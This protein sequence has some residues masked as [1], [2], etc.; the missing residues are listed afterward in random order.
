MKRTA[1]S[2]VVLAVA[3]ALYLLAEY[4]PPEPGT[5]APQP[6]AQGAPP[7]A[8]H[9]PPPGVR[10]ERVVPTLREAADYIL[11]TRE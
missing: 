5:A 3:A 10:A 8:R 6:S 7:P 2:L 11:S 9:E 1:I 4:R